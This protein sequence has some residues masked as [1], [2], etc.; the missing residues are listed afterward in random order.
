M[1]R[2]LKCPNCGK[3]G[4][5]EEC[6]CGSKKIEPKPPKYTPEDKYAHYRRMAKEHE[7]K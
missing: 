5:T 2:I 4:L 3:Y 7:K 1:K 6:T